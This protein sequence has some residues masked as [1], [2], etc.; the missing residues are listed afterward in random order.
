MRRRARCAAAILST[1]E[2]VVGKD[3]LDKEND[4][5]A[6][7]QESIKEVVSSNDSSL[8]HQYACDQ[9]DF[10]SSLVNGLIIHISV[11]H[12]ICFG[13]LDVQKTNED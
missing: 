10:I 1:A 9:C 7:S 11:M 4:V 2:S 3:T 12:E 6:Q 13:P 5:A 8:S